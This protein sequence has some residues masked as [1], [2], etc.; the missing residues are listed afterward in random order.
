[1]N[2]LASTLFGG[3][4]L[5]LLF[6]ICFGCVASAKALRR[7]MRKRDAERTKQ[8]KEIEPPTADQSEKNEKK[9]PQT[10]YYIVEKKRARPKNNY[11][12]PKEIKFR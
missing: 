5:F 10:V 7:E 6:G 12:E 2:L 3:L 1:M 9:Q 8:T 11:G 4:Y